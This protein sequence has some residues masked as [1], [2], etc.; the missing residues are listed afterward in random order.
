MQPLQ[1]FVPIMLS[2]LFVQNVL[3][4]ATAM[5]VPSPVTV[6]KEQPVNPMMESVCVPLDS[7][8]QGVQRVSLRKPFLLEV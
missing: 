1:Y 7:V 3:K 8:D 2:F 6:H 5:A 4:V